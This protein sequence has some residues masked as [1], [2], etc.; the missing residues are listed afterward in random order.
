MTREPGG[1][2]LGDRLRDILLRRHDLRTVPRSEALMM[3]A[4]RAQLVE[5]VILP[6]LAD[7]VTVVCDRYA[8]STLAY[9]GYGRGLDLDGLRAVL[10]FATRGLTPDMT[11]LL[12]LPVRDGLARKQAQ[13][14]GAMAEWNR[15]EAEDV[16]FHER[17]RAGYLELAMADPGRWTILDAAKPPDVLAE[18]VWTAVR[19]RLGR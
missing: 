8:D 4:S 17:V 7:G 9:Q 13:D 6:A 2:P 16:A 18:D 19:E 15:F 11:I 1:T 5:Q 12:D 10:S 3:C 14:E